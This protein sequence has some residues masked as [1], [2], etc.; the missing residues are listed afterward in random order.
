[1]F[2]SDDGRKLPFFDPLAILSLSNIIGVFA[3]VEI[4]FKSWSI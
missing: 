3:L 1:M 2:R 4:Y